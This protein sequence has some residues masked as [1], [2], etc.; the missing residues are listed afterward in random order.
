M[1]ASRTRPQGGAHEQGGAEATRGART[2]VDEALRFARRS[3]GPESTRLV[4]RAATQALVLSQVRAGLG[5]EDAV[6]AEVH[7]RMHEDRALANE[8]LAFFLSDLYRLGRP[9]LSPGLHR[10]L[11]TGDLAQSVLGDLW[12]QLGSLRF[13]TRSEF[14]SLLAQRLRWKSSDG[15][16]K[17]HRGEASLEELDPACAEPAEESGQDPLQRALDKDGHERLILTLT[18]LSERDRRLLAA[19]LQGEPLEAL[20]AELELGYEAAR[21]AQQRALARARRL[22]Q[23][24]V[25]RESR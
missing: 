7:R 1:D 22:V 14:L 9:M 10:F 13:R 16:R 2:L 19:H 17:A 8:F 25:A 24:D 18:R 11:D 21:K 15:A 3:L 5:V 4:G 12:P 23:D 6:L 20:M